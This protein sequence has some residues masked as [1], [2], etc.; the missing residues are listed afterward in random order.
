MPYRNHLYTQG[1]PTETPNEQASGY[2]K[3]DTAL[4]STVGLVSPSWDDKGAARGCKNEAAMNYEDTA[5]VNKG[6]RQDTGG[7]GFFMKTGM[8]EGNDREREKERGRET[9]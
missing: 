8:G 2:K 9:D 4:G 6:G 1:C 7:A 5:M 3:V